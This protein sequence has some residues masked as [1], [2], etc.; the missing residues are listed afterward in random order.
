MLAKIIIIIF[1]IMLVLYVFVSIFMLSYLKFFP[2]MTI[3]QNV[4]SAQRSAPTISNCTNQCKGE[5]S[6]IYCFTS[7]DK[8]V[9]QI[10]YSLCQGEFGNSCGL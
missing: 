5:S 10:C 6:D 3:Y 1:S 4:R 9:G 7:D 8:A 2:G